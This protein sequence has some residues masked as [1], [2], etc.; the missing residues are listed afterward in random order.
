MRRESDHRGF[1]KIIHLKYHQNSLKNL[2]NPYQ[3]QYYYKYS[4]TFIKANKTH[5]TPDTHTSIHDMELQDKIRRPSAM[6]V[7]ME[8]GGG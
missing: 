2:K 5:T 7:A 1:T 6:Q 8:G 3:C 4:Y